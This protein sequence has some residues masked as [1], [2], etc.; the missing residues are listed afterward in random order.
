[1]AADV[2]WKLKCLSR[3]PYRDKTGAGYSKRSLI[4]GL[5]GPGSSQRIVLIKKVTR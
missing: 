3:P 1:M 4:A 2:K 5:R